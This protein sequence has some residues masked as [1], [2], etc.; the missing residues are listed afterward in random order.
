MTIHF[1]LAKHPLLRDFRPTDRLAIFSLA[2]MDVKGWPKL[3]V[4]IFKLALLIPPFL[5]LANIDVWWQA[6]PVLLAIPL[7]P[8]LTR[9]V[10]LWAVSE[11]LPA[12]I[13]THQQQGASN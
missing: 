7:Y 6:L 2:Y 9:P 12:A 5:W 1:T 8:L 13:K 4:N 10:Q 11:L 3:A